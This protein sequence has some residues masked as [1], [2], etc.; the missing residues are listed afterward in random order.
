MANKKI[1]AALGIASALGVAAMPM[2][3]VWAAA[4]DVTEITDTV[5][6]VVESTCSF[7]TQGT[8]GAS[9]AVMA[10]EGAAANGQQ[11]A[12]QVS[13]AAKDTHVFNVVCNNN[14]GY[15]VTALATGLAS[16]QSGS[17][18]TIPFAQTSAYNTAV[19]NIATEDDGKWTATVLN[20]GTTGNMTIADK[21]KSTATDNTIVTNGDATD[22][23]GV[24]FSVQYKAFVGQSTQAGTYNGTVKYTLAPV[25]D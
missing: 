17:H 14:N 18:A 11:V 23:A 3:G 10:F 5:K 6:V 13:G 8:N 24:E 15:T 21:V 2:A 9:A 19:G 20:A 1:I 25:T 7:K 22:A 12:F 16:G 4:S